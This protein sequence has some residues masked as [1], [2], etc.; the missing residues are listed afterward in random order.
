VTRAAIPATAHKNKIL[1]RRERTLRKRH[2][3]FR[4]RDL[5]AAAIAEYTSASEIAITEVRF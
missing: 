4:F 5:A 3:V 2:R 1:I